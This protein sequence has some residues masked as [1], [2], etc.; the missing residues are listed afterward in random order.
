LWDVVETTVALL[1]GQQS[2]G[3]FPSD[4]VH[5]RLHHPRLEKKPSNRA[6]K[7][8]FHAIA[9]R[10]EIGEKNCKVGY[11]FEKYSSYTVKE[12]Q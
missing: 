2:A 11:T 10:L 6:L 3:R 9:T 8:L 5:G 1:P 12:G 7:G 4:V